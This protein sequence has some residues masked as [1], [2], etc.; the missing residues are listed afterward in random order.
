MVLLYFPYLSTMVDERSLL[1]A[2]NDVPFTQ[3]SSAME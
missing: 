1:A 2:R 3:D